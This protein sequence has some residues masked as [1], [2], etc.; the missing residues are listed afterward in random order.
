MDMDGGDPFAQYEDDGAPADR[1]DI[2]DVQSQ[3]RD[4]VQQQQRM[5]MLLQPQVQQQVQQQAMNAQGPQ[6]PYLPNLARGQKV[7]PK[8]V[9]NPFLH[10]VKIRSSISTYQGGFGDVFG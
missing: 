2:L 9:L 7:C 1:Q 5:M 4:L 6:G 3:I 10:I 8:G